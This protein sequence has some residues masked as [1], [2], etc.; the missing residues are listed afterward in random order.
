MNDKRLGELKAY[1]IEPWTAGQQGTYMED[2]LDVDHCR[3][4]LMNYMD[5][6]S[7]PNLKTAA[8]LFIKHYARVTV[9]STLHHLAQYNGAL[10]MPPAKLSLGADNKTL[11]V[12]NQAEL[13]VY[14]S[15]DEREVGRQQLLHEL[16]SL[17][18]T[19]LFNA[20][21]EATSVPYN[22]LWENVAVR[23]NSIYR[24]MLAQ[25][26]SEEIH[27]QVKSDF[28]FLQQAEGTL[29]DCNKNPISTYLNLEYPRNSSKTRRTC[30]FNYQ[31]GKQE[32]CGICPLLNPTLIQKE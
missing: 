30:C 8:S 12:K 18:I 6:T 19:P 25:Q 23:I 27:Q 13:W 22:I 29:F 14:L 21:K 10:R 31:V 9:A 7:A 4:F 3:S 20:M 17:H 15:K 5:A 26:V 16:F 1:R 32:Y 24:K 28:Q 2:L 11:Y